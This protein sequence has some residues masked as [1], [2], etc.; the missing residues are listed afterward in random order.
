MDLRERILEKAEELFFSFGFKAVT[1]EHISSDLGI[2]KKTLY[3]YFKDKNQLV[4]ETTTFVLTK[5]LQQ[6]DLI[7]LSKSDPIEQILDSTK[8]MR[9]ILSKVK[10][11][12]FFEM[13]K[14]HPSAWKLYV[15]FKKNF[16]LLVLD[17]F[18]RG[19]ELGLYRN[20][21]NEEILSELRMAQIELGFDTEH[22]PVGTFTPLQVQ[23]EF[24]DHFLRGILTQKG[25]EIYEKIK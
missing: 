4:E 6:E 19:K 12:I 7:K 3:Q 22:F 9:V 25:L 1:L 17:N 8:K 10:P 15:A 24:L 16:K 14:Y 11:G 13:Q 20:D 23:L 21:I 18:R 2:S 5:E